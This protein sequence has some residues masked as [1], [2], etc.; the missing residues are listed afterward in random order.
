MYLT[1]FT[2]VLSELVMLTDKTCG[3]ICSDISSFGLEV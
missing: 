1:G 2:T 3:S